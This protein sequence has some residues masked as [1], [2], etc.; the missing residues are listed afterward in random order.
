ME[1]G[2]AAYVCC[3]DGE[4]GPFLSNTLSCAGGGAQVVSEHDA[5]RRTVS[6]ESLNEPALRCFH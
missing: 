6:G 4:P 3:S 2:I 5:I 1:E